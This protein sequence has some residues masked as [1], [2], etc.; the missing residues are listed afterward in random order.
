MSSVTILVRLW[1]LWIFKG[2]KPAA[3]DFLR[4]ISEVGAERGVAGWGGDAGLP[5]AQHDAFGV[6]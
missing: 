4:K 3:F 5:P 6:V 1:S 2:G